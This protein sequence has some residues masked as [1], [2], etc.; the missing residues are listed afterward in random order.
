MWS[1]T[2]KSSRQANPVLRRALD[3][4]QINDKVSHFAPIWCWLSC[5][6]MHD[7]RSHVVAA[8]VGTAALGVA[9]EFWVLREYGEAMQQDDQ[10]GAK[11]MNSKRAVI[12]VRVRTSNRTK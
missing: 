3:Y 10:L 7:R 11:K 6:A 4:L 1:V 8:A 12:Y 9:L 2:L 5:R